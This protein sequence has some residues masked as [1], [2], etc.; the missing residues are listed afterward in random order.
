MINSH[1]LAAS[2]DALSQLLV[3]IGADSRLLDARDCLTFGRDESCDWHVDDDHVSRRH[4]F[5]FW[6]GRW[7]LKDL[8]STNGTFVDGRAVGVWEIGGAGSS[9]SVRLGDPDVGAKIEFV[10][11]GWRPSVQGEARATARMTAT[12]HSPAIVGRDSLIVDIALDPLVSRKHCEVSL[13]GNGLVVTDL[14]SRNG[15][16]VNGSRV[17]NSLLAPGDVVTVGTTDL[18]VTSEREL[19]VRPRPTSG[20]AK[21][22]NYSRVRMRARC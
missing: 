17:E 5:L 7:M 18:D 11:R 1:S 9:V 19:V 12:E 6:N 10:S 2:R 3:T 21:G 14:N 13:A 15:T 4:A 20:G 8:A 16:Y 22:R